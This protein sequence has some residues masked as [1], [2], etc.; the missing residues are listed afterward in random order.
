M[1]KNIN[2]I[3][4]GP[5]GSG[6]GTQARL[7]REKYD[8]QPLEVGNILRNIAKEDSDLGREIDDIINKKGQ[9]ASWEIVKKVLDHEVSKLDK[10]RGILFDGTPRRMEEVKY[11]EEELP[12]IGRKIDFIF[13]IN[14]SKEESL[15]RISS[16][17]LCKKNGHPLIVGKDIKEEDTLCPICQSDVYRRE[18]DTPEKV[19]KRLEINEEKLGPVVEY[20]DKK[21]MIK[22]I[23]GE[24]TIENIQKEIISYIE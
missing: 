10:N 6:K 1:A 23:N 19:L 12:K 20:F 2:V 21:N 13:Y 3:I 16:R 18:D 22:R 5:Q 9:Y 8:L 24:N 7:L 14:I 4:M 15:K 17:K 11:W